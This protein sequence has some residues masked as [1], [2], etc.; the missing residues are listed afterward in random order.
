MEQNDVCPICHGMGF[1]PYEKDNCNFARPCICR[2]P[3]RAMTMIEQSGIG[4]E[5]KEKGFKNFDDRNMDILK[6]AKAMGIDYCKKFPEIKNTSRNSVLY[7]GQCGAG[8]T[9][10]SVAIANAIMDTHKTAVVYMPYRE[11]ITRLK[12]R[13]LDESG[14]NSTI[15]RFKQAPVLIVDD[16]LKGKNSETDVNILFEIVN[17]RYL[18]RLP[19]IVSTEKTVDELLKFDEGCGS[20]ILEMSRGHCVEI[21]GSEY[22]YRLYGNRKE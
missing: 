10:L 12:Q 3:Q 20:R 9:H 7:C 14:F 16:L 5:F 2:E 13:A 8:K 17:F 15:D 1:V 21:I 4:E 19:M 6:K 18:K 22:N 11:W